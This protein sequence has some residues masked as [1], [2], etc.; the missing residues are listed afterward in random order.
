M[1]NLRAISTAAE[2]DPHHP[3]HGTNLQ[4]LS[5]KERGMTSPQ[6][7]AARLRPGELIA[8]TDAMIDAFKK[9][10][11]NTEPPVPWTD[12]TQ[13]PSESFQEFANRL[14]QAVQGSDLPKAA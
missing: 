8:A 5:G 1:T 2:V 14:L 3:V 6:A 4:W 11:S 12:I 7:Q 13:G 9:L 10:A